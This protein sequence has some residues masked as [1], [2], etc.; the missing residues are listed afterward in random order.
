MG[1]FLWPKV[2]RGPTSDYVVRKGLFEKW[3]LKRDLKSE[4]EPDGQRVER[5]SLHAEQHSPFLLS[6]FVFW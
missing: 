5:I 2:A 3:H 4:K 1:S 6:N